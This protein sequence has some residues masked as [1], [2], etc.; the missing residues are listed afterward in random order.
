MKGRRTESWHESRETSKTRK[1]QRPP[2]NAI[3]ITTGIGKSDLIAEGSPYSFRSQAPRIAAPR[4]DRVPTHKL[5]NEARIKMPAGITVAIWQGRDAIKLGTVDE[6]MCLNPEAV[7][8]AMEIGAA[9]EETACRKEVRGEDP[10]LCPFYDKCAYQAQKAAAR[11]AD[12][13]F[14]AHEILFKTPKASATEASA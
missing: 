6:K 9:V 4:P 7:K 8:A 13:L 11:E 5:A 12:V 3:K 2:Q 14:C 10:I 1:S